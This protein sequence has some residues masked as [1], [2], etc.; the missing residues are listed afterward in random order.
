MPDPF[1]EIGETLDRLEARMRE[2]TRPEPAPEPA[3]ARK[4][5]ESADNPVLASPAVSGRRSERRIGCEGSDGPSCARIR[6]VRA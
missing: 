5:D 6:R 1:T 2:F 4:A 3:P